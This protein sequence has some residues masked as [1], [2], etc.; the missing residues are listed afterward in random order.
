MFTRH[1]IGLVI[2]VG[3]LAPLA[4]ATDLVVDYTFARPAITQVNIAGTLY[5]RINMPDAPS[6]GLAG[7]P[8]LPVGGAKILIPYGEEVVGVEVTGDRVLIGSGYVIEPV[9][10]P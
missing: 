9:G 7:E 6:G 3:C 8:R 2:T 1:V 5:D 4:S 10:K